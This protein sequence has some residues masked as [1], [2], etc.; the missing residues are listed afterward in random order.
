MTP[1]PERDQLFIS[2]SHVDR[3]W[4][5]RLQTMIRPLVR[6]HGLRL[7]D[8]S[9]IQPGDKWREEFETALAAAWWRCCW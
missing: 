9:Q 5:V 1:R 3:D 7:W 4:V 8:D 6:S 2:Y